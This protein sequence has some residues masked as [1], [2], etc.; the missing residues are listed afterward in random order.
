MPYTDVRAN[1]SGKINKAG[2][3]RVQVDALSSMGVYVS[4]KSAIRLRLLLL[5]ALLL[6]VEVIE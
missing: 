4:I 5:K 6:S 1:P 3:F 2:V